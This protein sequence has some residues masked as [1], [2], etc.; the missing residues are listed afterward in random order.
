MR[1]G[2][3]K[4]EP[5]GNATVA[6]EDFSDN[7]YAVVTSHTTR[8]YR[9]RAQNLLTLRELT[10]QALTLLKAAAAAERARVKLG[11]EAKLIVA[12]VFGPA[13]VV[14]R[15]DRRAPKRMSRWLLAAHRYAIR[16]K[17]RTHR[18]G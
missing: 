11:T 16:L 9:W 7:E 17:P 13:G 2:R 14:C 12:E 6:S 4:T 10:G 8:A 15:Y 18:H 5:A 3:P 1:A